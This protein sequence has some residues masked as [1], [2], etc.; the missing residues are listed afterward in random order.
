MK[1]SIVWLV[2]LL[3][4][5]G[6]LF[7][8]DK[9]D[10]TFSVPANTVFLRKYSVNLEKGNKLQLEL[11]DI[12]DL[13][14]IYNVDSVLE[15]FAKD[16]ELLKDSINDPVTSKRID[17]IMDTMGNRKIRFK[18]Y[19]PKSSSFIVQQNE[20]AS[21]KI[22]QDTIIIIGMIP[23]PPKAHEQTSHKF[24]R[25]YRIT[26]YLND[27]SDLHTYMDNRITIKLKGLL[28]NQKAAKWYGGTTGWGNYKLKS[29][30]S[31]TADLRGG[32]AGSPKDF[33][34]FS[35]NVAV[36]NYKKYFV[37]SFGIGAFLVVSN[38]ERTFR[39]EVGLVWEPMFTFT[40]DSVKSTKT[41][42]SQFLTLVLSQG[43]VKDNDPRK[44]TSF[45]TTLSISYLI[46]RKGEVFEEN[47]FRLGMGK[48]KLLK[49]TIEPCMY[50]N[51]FFKGVTPGLRIVQSF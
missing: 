41:N 9:T 28:D 27:I 36:Q 17:Y 38:R 11:S 16:L 34:A 18:Q 24:A 35:G 13:Q 7:A 33:L 4:T 10:R 49:T 23:H 15:I 3:S 26:L 51:N 6:T 5:T 31:I 43:G 47:T 14:R 39:R 30:P 19:A 2:L 46:S 40:G 25:Y 48:L 20:L 42:M 1:V 45:I 12:T 22:E 50:F 21:L 8:Q 44:E 29:D 32:K 37:P